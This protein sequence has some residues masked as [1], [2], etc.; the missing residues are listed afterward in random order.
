VDT[1]STAAVSS[2]RSILAEE[3]P[4]KAIKIH[5]D[6]GVERRRA[7][8]RVIEHYDCG[9]FTARPYGGDGLPPSY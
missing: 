8:R 6:H 9:R 7:A 3:L 1:S 5:D 2:T 4:F